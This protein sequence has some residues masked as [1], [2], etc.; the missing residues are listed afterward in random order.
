MTAM[1]TFLSLLVLNYVCGVVSDNKFQFV[2]EV[3]GVL[4]FKVEWTYMQESSE[5]LFNVS[6]RNTAGWSALGISKYKYN[7]TN[8]DIMMIN[9]TTENIKV[10]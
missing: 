6:A 1:K 8:M 9:G 10:K 3:I 4:R 7:M 5:I 2:D